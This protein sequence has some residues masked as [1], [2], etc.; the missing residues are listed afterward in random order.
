MRNHVYFGAALLQATPAVNKDVFADE[1]DKS[2]VNKFN[3]HW[4]PEY[5][6][7]GSGYRC[8]RIGTREMDAAVAMAIQRSGLEAG[9]VSEG[10][11]H[12]LSIWG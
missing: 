9:E 11:Q 2:L 10:L 3:G 8:L 6:C 4:Y 7:K 12:E 1:L 5:P